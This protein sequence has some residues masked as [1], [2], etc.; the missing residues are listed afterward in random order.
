V[1]EREGLARTRL[2]SE[3]S[4]ARD[5]VVE[6]RSTGQKADDDLLR[7]FTVFETAGKLG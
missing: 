7:F 4:R 2:R 1:R 5:Y 6:E 3:P